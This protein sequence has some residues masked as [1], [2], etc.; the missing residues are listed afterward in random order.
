MSEALLEVITHYNSV[1]RKENLQEELDTVKA[2]VWKACHYRNKPV[3]VCFFPYIV[4][5][6]KAVF[7]EPAGQRP[8]EVNNDA[9]CHNS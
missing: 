1:L 7:W 2:E 4:K 8:K 6:D 3:G 5:K 9:P